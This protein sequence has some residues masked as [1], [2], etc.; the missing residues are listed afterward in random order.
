MISP[1][2]IAHPGQARRHRAARARRAIV[3]HLPAHDAIDRVEVAGPG[4]INFFVHQR[5]SHACCNVSEE[6]GDRFGASQL[7]QGQKIQVEF[8]SANPTGPLHVGHGRGAA[9]GAT[10]ANLLAFTG[11]DG[12]EGVLRQRCRSP[13][14]HSRH[15]GLVALPRSVRRNPD[16]FPSNGYRA[17]T[18]GIS[19]RRCIERTATSPCATLSPRSS[20]CR[21]HRR[22]ARR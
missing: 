19:R 9:F 5:T 10:L 7:G 18:S 13:D 14:A 12:A 2:N 6:Q 16:R 4:F 22:R 8:V 21:C 1:S 17:I 3:E 20:V 11:F 15:L